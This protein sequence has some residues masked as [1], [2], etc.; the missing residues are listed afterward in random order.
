MTAQ[1]LSN[2][3]N[4]VII[5]GLIVLLVLM[6]FHA[7]F[8]IAL[9]SLG[10]NRTL[11]QSW[12]EI[13]VLIMSAA[14]LGYCLT[15]KS[16]AFKRDATNILFIIIVILSLAVTS[17]VNPG[18]SAVLYGIKTNLV[19]IAL[20]LISQIPATTK[21][22]LKR[23]LHLLVIIP[24]LVVALLALL[25]FFVLKP[26]FLEKLGYG[27]STINP[28][29]IVDGSLS[30]YRS[31]STLGGPNQL[32]AYLILPLVFSI[33]FAIRNKNPLLG[34]AAVPII[35][36]IVV[37]FSRSAWIGA[38][39]ASITAVAI[40]LNNKQRIVLAVASSLVI[41]L[42]GFVL[43]SQ[44][45]RNSR[46]ENVILHGRFFENRIEGSDQQRLVALEKSTELI[47]QEP[48]GHGL[49]SAGPASFQSDSPV[50]SENWYLQIG[51]ELGVIGL[52]LYIAAF[53]SLLGEF[54]R[55]L[56]NSLAAALFAATIGLLATNIFLHAWADSTLVLIT[57]SLYGLYKG[58]SA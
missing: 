35:A 1:K 57:F 18:A 16:I 45:G 31:F 44:I 29:Q 28:R 48:F 39:L 34:L 4:R 40:V 58:R 50:I 10:A 33:V 14:W 42:A 30:F 56:E 46:L 41:V 26:E 37:S 9:G 32:G 7:F 52:I 22:F 8:A 19:A 47:S 38:I 53:V 24:G 2:I 3:F 5:Y 49:G 20:L 6:P 13:L 21:S 55:N 43:F 54:F 27:T 23:N 15:K 11:V 17:F 36:A 25:Q 12:K 51:Y